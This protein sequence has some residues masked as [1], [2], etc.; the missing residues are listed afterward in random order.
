MKS[1]FNASNIA[2][3]VVALFFLGVSLFIQPFSKLTFTSDAA[4]PILISVLCLIFAIWIVI[5]ER[6]KK[7]AA[8]AQAKN[9]QTDKASPIDTAQPDPEAQKSPEETDKAE[10]QDEDTS[11]GALNR[12]VLVI[13]GL[14]VIYAVL[15]M[16][17]GYIISTL[18]FT[19]LAIA[20]LHNEGAK[21]GLKVGVLVGFIATFLIV[22]VFKYG[23]SVILP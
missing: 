18:V 5:E 16:T 7:K 17:V 19:A 6:H 14:M 10:A 12:D 3:I 9:A 21:H 15:L 1:K 11:T 22:L 23:F 4:Y 2:V 20:Y 13:I 8:E